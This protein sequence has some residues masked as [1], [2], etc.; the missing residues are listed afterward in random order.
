M[1]QQNQRPSP[2]G[3]LSLADWLVPVHYL[4]R[5]V[6]FPQARTGRPTNLPPLDQLLDDQRAAARAVDAGAGE[7][8][9]VGTFVGRDDLFFQLEAAGRLQKVVVLHGPAGTGKTELAKA[10]G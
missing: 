3:E 4:R 1:Y 9:A 7:L 6:S 2:K 5:D 10:F 8:D